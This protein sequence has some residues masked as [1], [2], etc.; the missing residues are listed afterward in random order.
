M[1]VPYDVE[2]KQSGPPR[3]VTW[4]GDVMITVLPRSGRVTGDA[5][6]LVA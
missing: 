6:R 2:G 5:K 4:L 3:E 1:M